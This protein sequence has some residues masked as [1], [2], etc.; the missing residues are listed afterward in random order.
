MRIGFWVGFAFFTALGLGE[1][2]FAALSFP[3]D[4]GQIETLLK[5]GAGV[6]SVEGFLAQLPEASRQHSVLLFH[7]RSLQ[8]ATADKPRAIVFGTDGTFFLAFN[9]TPGDRKYRA[10]EMLE[11]IASENRFEL[12]EI[13][14]SR[15]KG[16]LSAANP[17]VCLGCHGQ[18]PH[19]LWNPYPFW[20]GAFE[21]R[22]HEEDSPE[23]EPLKKN[24]R[25]TLPKD[26]RYH[27]LPRN[28]VD[29][30]LS[31]ENVY[32][33]HFFFEGNFKRISRFI[34]AS[35]FAQ[36]YRYAVA[37]AL[38]CYNNGRAGIPHF[39]REVMPESLARRHEDSLKSGM[40]LDSDKSNFTYLDALFDARGISTVQWATS[41][42]K[43][44]S[45]ALSRFG[46]TDADAFSSSSLLAYQLYDNVPEIHTSQLKTDLRKIAVDPSNPFSLFAI[47]ENSYCDEIKVK[48]R[49][50]LEKLL[51]H[52]SP[53][54]IFARSKIPD[55]GRTPLDALEMCALCHDGGAAPEIPFTN[56]GMLSRRLKDDVG[57][58]EKLR[59]RLGPD[60]GSQVMPPDGSFS[61]QERRNLLEF[62]ERI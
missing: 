8:S 47:P 6:D 10:V 22:R 20:E 11:F 7:S 15:G 2:A 26:P 46:I 21:E 9:N 23:L 32:L 43:L 62:L 28:R 13:D 57:L 58:R 33:T 42:G 29:S 12:R 39:L 45:S 48:S 30:E 60:A 52:H 5:S 18:D 19:P 55:V 3:V 36:D 56:I 25:E 44:D 54:E 41:V 53:G 38:L 37:T 59:L 17:P 24:F 40:L 34:Q 16:Q 50:A 51:A 31:I 49:N 61:M 35:A 14:F 27:F 1:T 4:F